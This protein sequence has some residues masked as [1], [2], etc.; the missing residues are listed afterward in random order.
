MS[1]SRFKVICAGTRFGKD[2]K[3]QTQLLIEAMEAVGIDVP[4]EL[5]EFRHN[6]FVKRHVRE[7]PPTNQPGG[8]TLRDVGI[9]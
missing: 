1:S 5:Y 6:E 2:E 4:D 7:F 9:F 3:S 8:K